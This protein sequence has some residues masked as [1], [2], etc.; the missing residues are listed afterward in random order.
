MSM[1]FVTFNQD[2]SHLAVGKWLGAA[3]HKG[4]VLSLCSR[5]LKGLQNLHY[6]SLL[7]MLRV[8]ARRYCAPRNALL[9]IF[10]CS[11]TLST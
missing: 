5:Y 4:F 8:K 10:G 9:Y 11:H 6:G 1:N 7:E 2:Y 3:T